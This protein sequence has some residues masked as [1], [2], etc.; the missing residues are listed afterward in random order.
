MSLLQYI[1]EGDWQRSGVSSIGY[2]NYEIR[3][4]GKKGNFKAGKNLLLDL[5]SP[6]ALLRATVDWGGKQE[7]IRSQLRQENIDDQLYLTGH[8]EAE[9]HNSSKRVRTF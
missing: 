1:E 5:Y 3:A 7:N 6:L 8:E 4:T 9:D 2:I